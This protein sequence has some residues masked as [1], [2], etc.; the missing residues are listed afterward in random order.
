MKNLKQGQNFI[1]NPDFSSDSEFEDDEDDLSSDSKTNAEEPKPLG[2]TAII[3]E[4]INPA[5]KNQASMDFEHQLK[6][7]KNNLIRVL[8]DTGSDGDLMFH[9]KRTYKR[10]PFLARQ[11]PK[12]WHT[13]N[14]SS[15][16]KEEQ[17]STSNSLS[18]PTASKS[19]LHQM[20]WS[21]ME[22]GWPSQCLTS[23]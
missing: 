8:S 23:S 18:T 2:V 4:M 5:T 17:K 19:W 21:M 22:R 13:S 12:S 11:V 14:G 9:E 20:L 7:R 10:F 15:K 16:P 3:A 6:H 1:A